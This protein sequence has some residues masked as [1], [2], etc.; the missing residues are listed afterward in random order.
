MHF[1]ERMVQHDKDLH[2]QDDNSELNNG[3]QNAKKNNMANM[4]RNKAYRNASKSALSSSGSSIFSLNVEL[5]LSAEANLDSNHC[6]YPGIG[7][8][9]AN[10][11][12]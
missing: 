12:S 9:V 6:M 4:H 5:D 2:I 11:L 7:L 1:E 8:S 3:E 10:V